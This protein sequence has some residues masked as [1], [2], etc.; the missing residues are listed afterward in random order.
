LRTVVIASRVLFVT[1]DLRAADI[2]AHE[3]SR[4][5][6]E[7]AFD[8]CAPAEEAA[9]RTAEGRHAAVLID[10][11][12]SAVRLATIAAIRGVDA[13]L[14]V[15]VLT[16]AGD[17][18]AGDLLEA[19]A[20]AVLSKRSTFLPRVLG[21]LQTLT[22]ERVEEDEPVCV[23]AF[24]LPTPEVARI[25]QYSGAIVHQASLGPD[26]SYS[27]PAGPPDLDQYDVA[28]VDEEGLGEVAAMELLADLRAR[29]PLLSVLALTRADSPCSLLAR[30]LHVHELAADLPDRPLALAH[31]LPSLRHAHLLGR[32]TAGLRANELRIRTII[33][34]AP[35]CISLF[36]EEGTCLAMNWAGLSALEVRRIE[37]I[38]G[39]PFVP[40][41]AEHDQDAFRDFL[42]TVADGRQASTTVEWIGDDG[43]RRRIEA[44]G[45]PLL[46]EPGGPYGILASFVRAGEE[47]GEPESAVESRERVDALVV[48]VDALRARAASLE[49]QLAARPEPT[50][51]DQSEIDELRGRC[52]LLETWL[53]EAE[54]RSDELGRQLA[55]EGNQHQEALAAA[56]AEIEGLAALRVERDELHARL[57]SLV[58]E[59]GEVTT[60]RARLE[61]ELE[62][63]ER[64]AASLAATLDAARAES[65]GRADT[66]QEELAA[67]AQEVERQRAAAERELK[68]LRVELER[69]RNTADEREARIRALEAAGLDRQRLR[70]R[71][72][73]ELA[74]ER[75]EREATADALARATAGERDGAEAA[76]RATAVEAALRALE[77]RYADLEEAHRRA[78]SAAEHAAAEHARLR[79]EAA[80]ALSVRDALEERVRAAE[81]ALR[82][83]D[84]AARRTADV[85][86]GAEDAARA[87]G[88]RAAE[89]RASRE[90]LEATADE[91]RAELARAHASRA[92]LEAMHARAV[93]D[94]AETRSVV[95]RD[96]PMLESLRN[97]QAILQ[98]RLSDEAGRRVQLEREL[99]DRQAA[100]GRAETELRARTERVG[101]LE[102]ER[103]RLQSTLAAAQAELSR[104]RDEWSHGDT[105]TRLAGDE[106]RRLQQELQALQ[107]ARDEAVARQGEERSRSKRLARKVDRLRLRI[108][109]QLRRAEALE[110]QAAQAAREAS[111]LAQAKRAAEERLERVERELRTV[112]TAL[113]Q[114]RLAAAD[115]ART[116][117]LYES[118]LE[119]TT[120][121]HDRLDAAFAET[122]DQRRLLEEYRS[123]Q[124]SLETGL[125]SAEATLQQL[126]STLRDDRQRSES[127]Q[128]ELVRYRQQWR[129]QGGELDR[130]RQQL[131]TTK[132]E[133]EAQR[134]LV[135]D[136]L[137]ARSTLQELLEERDRQSQQDADRHDEEVR[138][139]QRSLRLLETQ[140]DRL[141][142][143]EFVGVALT[144]MDGDVMR[145][146]RAL[147]AML[148]LSSTAELVGPSSPLPPPEP[149][150][151][152]IA[153]REG[154]AREI[155]IERPDGRTV[156][157]L[158]HASLLR[159]TDNEPIAERVFIDVTRIREL[160][161]H[162]REARRLESVGRLT[163]TMVEDLQQL[164]TLV[165]SGV[166]ELGNGGRGE[167]RTLA[168][169]TRAATRALAL[170]NQLQAHTRRQLREVEGVDAG[171]LL[172]NALPMLKRLLG[173]DVEL[174]VEEP[175]RP[176]L[177]AVDRTAFEQLLTSLVVTGRDALSQGGT[178]TLS[179]AVE[180]EP[181]AGDDRPSGLL[182][183][184]LQGYGLELAATSQLGTPVGR[185]DGRLD[186]T[187]AATE[188]VLRVAVPRLETA[189]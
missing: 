52:E 30:R 26:G 88:A 77:T 183:M 124:A 103:D 24:G 41:I 179:T 107:Q 91:V 25:I 112:A 17:P 72:E 78:R 120:R 9:T 158:E 171:A 14:P 57:D 29:H 81:S 49:E 2:V 126:V 143:V 156:W 160:G 96:R 104:L 172:R 53:Y 10:V 99:A 189:E 131:R 149:E 151:A 51:V 109:H 68:A 86:R 33:E 97:D 42:H 21:L 93:H 178:M 161:Q 102:G 34:A 80:S 180:A 59:L 11:M 47:P 133:L 48:E 4:L 16:A 175:E 177:L 187:T 37:D 184:T 110:Q 46:R 94:L 38:V 128:R 6:P 154:L 92:D 84:D 106:R 63:S 75:Q 118:R 5:S 12:P 95:E 73:Q 32:E 139:L 71:L 125:R 45:V 185:C 55:A 170:V 7:V 66:L 54:V 119:E 155:N 90:R 108:E 167:K 13:H 164:L 98:Q 123:L 40:R 186:V 122:A 157:L 138:R 142:D 36:T 165:R 79:D 140:L 50:P 141:S 174:R 137:V 153:E 173:D 113:D 145:A 159:D 74:H 83:A 39:Q 61:A 28:M 65:S 132:D 31:L 182:V 115:L 162:L 101:A 130:L 23:A 3:S 176:L 44:S 105:L 70:E 18:E 169:A 146:N 117:R 67:A 87:A 181:R 116:A 89:E 56:R 111:E 35:A 27:S 134:R 19:G 168:D 188:A 144:T 135:H 136:H 58:S 152:A 163:T 114:E 100:L 85:V 20:S 121:L 127:S 69:A 76:A 1:A 8:A 166:T 62:E 15:V 82:A 64:H 43:A 129:E 60:A 147:A 148:G 150:L 22:K